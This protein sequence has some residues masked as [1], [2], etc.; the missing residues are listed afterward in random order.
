M[1]PT[2][3][4][5]PPADQ[6]QKKRVPKQRREVGW[7]ILMWGTLMFAGSPS[8][9]CVVRSLD[10]AQAGVAIWTVEDSESDHSHESWQFIPSCVFGRVCT[11]GRKLNAF[12]KTVARNS[13]HRDLLNS[14]RCRMQFIFLYYD[15]N[16]NGR[17]E[18]EEAGYT[19]WSA[20]FP[21]IRGRILVLFV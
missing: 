15:Q 2:P 9:V 5:N 17:L 6:S 18:I 8:D 10:T 4:R 1:R 7:L 20:V 13:H 12:S 11:G 14:L 16:R 19:R 21:G 3:P